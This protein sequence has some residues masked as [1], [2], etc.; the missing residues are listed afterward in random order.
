MAKRVTSDARRRD[1]HELVYRPQDK[2]TRDLRTANMTFDPAHRCVNDRY[3]V[4][5]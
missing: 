2:K 1:C 5:V 3:A 4:C